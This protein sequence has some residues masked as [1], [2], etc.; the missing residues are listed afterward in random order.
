M[1]HDPL[2]FQ[3]L[4]VAGEGQTVSQD[5]LLLRQIFYGPNAVQAQ[6]TWASAL[7]KS[8]KTFGRLMNNLPCSGFLC[9]VGNDRGEKP[10]DLFRGN[11]GYGRMIK[12]PAGGAYHITPQLA[13]CPNCGHSDLSMRNRSS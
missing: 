13:N 8:A 2:H 4:A 3:F 1:L 10:T 5:N 12:A 11:T 9:G 7:W 6:T